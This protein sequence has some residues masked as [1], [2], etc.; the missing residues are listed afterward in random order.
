[1]SVGTPLAAAGLVH[2]PATTSTAAAFFELVIGDTSASGTRKL[3]ATL[4]HP[5]AV[6]LLPVL[7]LWDVLLM[8]RVEELSAP[9]G[10]LGLPVEA[11]DVS[12]VNNSRDL[13][14]S[15]VCAHDLLMLGASEAV[16]SGVTPERRGPS[17]R[18]SNSGVASPDVDKQSDLDVSSVRDALQ[19]QSNAP[20]GG[21][22]GLWGGLFGMSAY[23]LPRHAAKVA[24]KR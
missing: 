13:E 10:G 4:P 7:A 17:Q 22:G 23:S 15:P 12:L 5:E 9:A 14:S 19:Q 2:A 18:C 3:A 1:M 24:N 20:V 6:S 11:D 21:A 8:G 16:S